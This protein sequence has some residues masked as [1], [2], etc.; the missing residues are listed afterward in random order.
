MISIEQN[1]QEASLWESL[2]ADGGQTDASEFSSFLSYLEEPRLMVVGV[3]GRGCHWVSQLASGSPHEVELVAADT[4]L[5]DLHNSLAHRKL[6]L[7]EQV[8]G[9]QGCDGEP[10]IGKAAAMESSDQLRSL[11]QGVEVMV[12]ACAPGGGTGSGAAPVLAGIA[13]EMGV[14]T[15]AVVPA[16]PPRDSNVK[17]CAAEGVARLREEANVLLCIGDPSTQRQGE[18]V[19]KLD[20]HPLVAVLRHLQPRLGEESPLLAALRQAAAGKKLV[21]HVAVSDGLDFGNLRAA[22]D[23]GLPAKE[24]HCLSGPGKYLLCHI[25]GEAHRAARAAAELAEHAR[26]REAADVEVTVTFRPDEHMGD[27]FSLVV[28]LME[29]LATEAPEAE[30]IAEEASPTE[31]ESWFDVREPQFAVACAEL[32]ASETMEPELTP[33]PPEDFVRRLRRAIDGVLRGQGSSSF[34]ELTHLCQEVDRPA[35]LQQEVVDEILKALGALAER[36]SEGTPALLPEERALLARVPSI[37]ASLCIGAEIVAVPAR[38]LAAELGEL[39]DNYASAQAS[40]EET[41][42]ELFADGSALELLAV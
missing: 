18:E 31:P 9:G 42:S 29:P 14:T 40:L 11:C 25:E 23:A 2:D 7:G 28:C 26:K 19:G 15:V 4:D 5:T 3:G 36:W 27:R 13:R 22:L 24:D 20:S 1:G 34:G 30:P 17:R 16:Q 41:P 33:T 32:M 37:L 38:T 39:L 8:A 12:I 21:G 35:P 10:L 6:L